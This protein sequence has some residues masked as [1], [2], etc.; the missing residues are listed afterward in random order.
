METFEKNI[1][2]IKVS[3]H[4]TKIKEERQVIIHCTYKGF[5]RIRIWKTTFLVAKNSKHRSKLI[6]AENISLYPE[7]TVKK[8]NERGFTL[9]FTGLPK[10]CKQFDFIE[11]I[12]EPGGWM[13]KNIKR[14][15]SDVYSIDVF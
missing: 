5:G 15:N 7:W 14:N 12:P 4:L 13:V 3:K 9:I 6:H 2:T 1:E 10:N 8:V 11:D